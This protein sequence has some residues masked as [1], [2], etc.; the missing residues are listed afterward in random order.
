MAK[1]KIQKTYTGAAGYQAGAT[2]NVDQYVSPITI[3]SSNIGGTGGNEDE[4]VYYPHPLS[5]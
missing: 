3:N 1:L 4:T 5:A 2:I